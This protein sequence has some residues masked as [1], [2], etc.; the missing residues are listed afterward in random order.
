MAVFLYS[1]LDFYIYKRFAFLTDDDNIPQN[2]C[3][4]DCVK[5]D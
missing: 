4:Q 5:C 3:Y 2:K 1:F